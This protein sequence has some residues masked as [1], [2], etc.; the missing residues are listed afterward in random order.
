MAMESEIVRS[1][2]H[3]SAVSDIK[4]RIIAN[5]GNVATCWGKA[6]ANQRFAA[7]RYGE[8]SRNASPLSSYLSHSNS[9]RKV[10]SCS[11]IAITYGRYTPWK[12]VPAS[13][14]QSLEFGI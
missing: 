7:V 13:P 4:D 6:T 12:K 9:A 1:A 3:T 2:T 8:T 11:M 14:A 5:P 10:I